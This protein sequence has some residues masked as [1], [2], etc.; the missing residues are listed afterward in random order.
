MSPKMIDG[1]DV[2]IRRSQTLNIAVTATAHATTINDV[3]A[4]AKLCFRPNYK[5]E[6]RKSSTK[7][8]S[9]LT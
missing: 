8:D 3:L 6:S 9:K 4:M 7:I 1:A 5:G 2:D